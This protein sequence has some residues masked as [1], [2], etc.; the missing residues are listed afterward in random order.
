MMPR[1][2][3]PEYQPRTRLSK[4]G[5][6]EIYDV[7]RRKFV[8]LTPEEWVRQHFINFFVSHHDYPLS[9]LQVEG[10][11][12]YNHLTKRS[13]IVV[14]GRNGKPLMAVE[15]KAP[16][17]EITQK[18]FDQLAM[19]NF[20]L[21]VSYLVLTNGMQNYICRMEPEKGSYSFLEKFPAYAELHEQFRD[22]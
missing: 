8:R 3:L 5:K 15:C 20:T 10:K 17:V 2:N 21:G 18:V 13:D 4:D 11:L 9:L 14:Y 16:S 1:L 6:E 7:V 22:L 19:Y 12:T